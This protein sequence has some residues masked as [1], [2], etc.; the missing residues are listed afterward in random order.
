MKLQISIAVVLPA[1]MVIGGVVRRD[2]RSV[3]NIIS[4][5]MMSPDNGILHLGDDGILRSFAENGT[6]IDYARLTVSQLMTVA[7]WSSGEQRSHLQAIWA[8]VNSFE[9][10]DDQIWSPPVNLLPVTMR[11]PPPDSPAPQNELDLR[12]IPPLLCQDIQCRNHMACRRRGCER[13]F[14]QDAIAKGFCI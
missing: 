13:C 14:I 12:M 9:V 8:N 11:E 5:L 6:V 2:V 7:D 4:S 1:V 10:E 3:S